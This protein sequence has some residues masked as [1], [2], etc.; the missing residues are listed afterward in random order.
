MWDQTQLQHVT[1]FAE[2]SFQ[3]SDD[4]DAWLATGYQTKSDEEKC[5]K[6]DSDVCGKEEKTERGK[7]II[8]SGHN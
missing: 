4:H 5:E 2:K 7:D 3:F 8:A 6:D 1:P